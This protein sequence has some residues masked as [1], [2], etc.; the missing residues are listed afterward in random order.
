MIKAMRFYS[1]L[2]ALLA[3]LFAFG[4]SDSSKTYPG[5]LKFNDSDYYVSYPKSF[6]VNFDGMS[7]MRIQMMTQR[8]SDADMFLENFGLL[9]EVNYN[10]DT[11]LEHYVEASMSQLVLVVSDFKLL[12]STDSTINGFKCHKLVYTGTFGDFKLKWEQ[13]IYLQNGRAYI[14]TFTSTLDNFDVICP[15]FEKVVGT[16]EIK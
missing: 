8:E 2:I 6:D 16:F 11:K 15:I 13:F 4:Q 12:E 10:P 5:W 3:P 7:G 1:I 9:S 14:W